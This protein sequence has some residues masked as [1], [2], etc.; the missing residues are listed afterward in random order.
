MIVHCSMR[1]NFLDR[2]HVS[3]TAGVACVSDPQLSQKMWKSTLLDSVHSRNHNGR[4][5]TQTVLQNGEK[6]GCELAVW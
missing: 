3:F 1:Y 4:W 2:K 6:S 5:E